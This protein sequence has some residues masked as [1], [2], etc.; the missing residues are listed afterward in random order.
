[1][2]TSI[3]FNC[4]LSYLSL[5]KINMTFKSLLNQNLIIIYQIS[6]NNFKSYINFVKIKKNINPPNNITRPVTNLML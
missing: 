1:M 2:V 4:K 6:N 5:S 3:M